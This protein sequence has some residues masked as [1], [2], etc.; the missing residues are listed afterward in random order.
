MQRTLLPL[1]A[2][3]TRSRSWPST[4]TT[5]P[6]LEASTASATRRTIALPPISTRSLLT[7]P[8]RRDC[9]AARM[10]AA[11]RGRRG[12]TGFGARQGAARNFRQ[13]TTGAHPH[14]VLARHRGSSEEPLQHP[15]EAVLLG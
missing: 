2:A 8:M 11:I 7:S 3:R 10:S 13:E 5:G 1:K 14:D 15:I 12:T 4:A 9:P 6:T